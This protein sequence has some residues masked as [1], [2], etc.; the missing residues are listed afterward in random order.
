MVP[1]LSSVEANWALVKSQAI[2]GNAPKIDTWSKGAREVEIRRRI[3]VGRIGNLGESILLTKG[4]AKDQ[5]KSEADDKG[6]KVKTK[7]IRP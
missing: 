2:Q 7:H 3:S 4:T 6:I 1:P 5:K